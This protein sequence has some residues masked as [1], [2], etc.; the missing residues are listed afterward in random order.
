MKGRIDA[1]LRRRDFAD[2]IK[3][4]PC[5]AEAWF[6]R[7]MGRWWLVDQQGAEMDMREAVH[8]KPILKEALDRAVKQAPPK[9][10]EKVL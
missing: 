9:P 5:Y 3:L 8:L 10:A 1:N 2:G 6:N 4:D 7:G